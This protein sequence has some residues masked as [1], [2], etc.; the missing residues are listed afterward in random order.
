L[1][2][3]SCS[4]S[5]QHPQPGTLRQKDVDDHQVARLGIARHPLHCRVLVCRSAHDIDADEFLQCSDQVL[6][7]HGAVLDD[8]G[9]QVSHACCVKKMPG[10]SSVP[11]GHGE[12]CWIIA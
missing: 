7:Y 2:G 4:R 3:L 12:R 8:V 1:V 10:W 5:L 9:F 11:D 6:A